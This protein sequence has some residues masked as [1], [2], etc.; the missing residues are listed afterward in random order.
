MRTIDDVHILFSET[1]TTAAGL[2]ASSLHAD[3][4][5]V[6]RC[7]DQRDLGLACSALRG[8]ACPLESEPIDV[9]VT[10]RT[11][12]GVRPQIGDDGVFCAIRRRLPVVVAGTARTHPFLRFAHT[13][14]RAGQSLADAVEAATA[15]LPDHSRVA[16]LEAQR[17]AGPDAIATVTRR[18]GG[19]FVEIDAVGDKRERTAVRVAGAVRAFDPYAPS[20]DVSAR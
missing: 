8:G 14:P 11:D 13:R 2:A 17:C 18:H 1:V 3:G 7:H 20:I 4:H 9:A 19:L 16:T 6:H 5:A 12:E 15:S 10:V